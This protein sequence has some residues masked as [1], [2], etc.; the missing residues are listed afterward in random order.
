MK[1]FLKVSFSKTLYAGGETLHWKTEPRLQ[2]KSVC[3]SV[4][5]H[6]GDLAVFPPAGRP[7][8]E[9]PFRSPP[10]DS[11][12]EAS[13]L[14]RWAV[15]LRSLRSPPAGGG[16]LRWE[17]PTVAAWAAWGRS[18]DPRGRS[19]PAP[20]SR[21]GVAVEFCL[22]SDPL[23]R[24][25]LRQ[26]QI[27]LDRDSHVGQRKWIHLTSVVSRLLGDVVQDGIV[28]PATDSGFVGSESSRLTPAAAASPVHQR[29]ME[30]WGP[31][32]FHSSLLSH[33]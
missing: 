25:C 2:I 13:L 30:R 23:H 29:A 31:N 9:T 22:R 16:H 27:C 28:S 26:L 12:A 32:T 5:W 17:G 6:R 8:V 4:P 14:T 15:P 20:N 1:Q 33:T 10:S 24:H 11:R 18:L 3:L 19:T 7:T 21:V